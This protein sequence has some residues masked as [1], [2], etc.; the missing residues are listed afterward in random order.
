MDS[1]EPALRPSVKHLREYLEIPDGRYLRWKAYYEDE[2]W[3]RAVYVYRTLHS[4]HAVGELAPS[5][6]E[7]FEQ[8]RAAMSH[9]VADERR[10]YR[11]VRCRLPATVR[12]QREL[13][14][15]DVNVRTLDLSASGARIGGLD[16]DIEGEL[17]WLLYQQTLVDD[18]LL[19]FPARGIWTRNGL[20][21]VRFAGPP[22]RIRVG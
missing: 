20:A 15:I 7:R 4:Q 10:A 3:L 21:G 14:L 17:L 13:N 22:R 18:G 16:I 19:I 2:L 5:Q 8:L 6:R 1:I 11:R 9:I 12:V